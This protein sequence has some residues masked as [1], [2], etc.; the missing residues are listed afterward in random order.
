MIRNHLVT[1]ILLSGLIL[2]GTATVAGAANIARL[3]FTSAPGDFIG[4]GQTVDLTYD[5]ALGDTIFVNINNNRLADG[6][7]TELSWTLDRPSTPANEFAGVSFGTKSLG[8]AIGVGSYP[9]A[10][11]DAFAP[12]GFAGL[13]IDFQNRG[14]NTLFGSFTINQISFSPD[15]SQI[16]TFD[17]NFEQRSERATA[18]AL[19]GRFQYN[20]AAVTTPPTD[21]TAVP[22][23]SDLL[24]LVGVGGLL[25]YRIRRDRKVTTLAKKIQ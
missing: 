2:T 10:R 18:P 1:S 12:L 16:L 25:I 3:S 15:K 7:P 4:Q 21:P 19:T 14:S 5:T 6:S 11:R 22:E 24:S 13:D 9:N 8:T 23:P 20:I 17:A